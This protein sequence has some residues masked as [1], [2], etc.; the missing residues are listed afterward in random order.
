[1][2]ALIETLSCLVAKLL[3]IGSFEVTQGVIL[4]HQVG[5][6]YCLEVVKSIVASKDQPKVG[7]Q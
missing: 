1:V 5:G 7:P 3:F 2:A 4:T 6:K